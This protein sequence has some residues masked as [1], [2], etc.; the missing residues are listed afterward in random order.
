LG[1][2]GLQ[3]LEAL[4]P[5]GDLGRGLAEDDGEEGDVRAL[6]QLLQLLLNRQ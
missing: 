2:G 3:L 4:A 6:G 1:A 5:A